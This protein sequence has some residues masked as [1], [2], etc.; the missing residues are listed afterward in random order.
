MQNREPAMHPK[1]Q[2]M[3]PV[4]EGWLQWLCIA[5]LWITGQTSFMLVENM[6]AKSSLSSLRTLIFSSAVS[7]A[8]SDETEQM[9]MVT[10]KT[11]K[12]SSSTR[13]H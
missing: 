7:D 4:V 9:W 11:T 8:L 5:Q 2:S 6:S 13:G 3:A 12:E 1:S 10:R